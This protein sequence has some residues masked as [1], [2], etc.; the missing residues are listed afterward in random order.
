MVKKRGRPKG[1]LDLKRI[2]YVM[3][4]KLDDYLLQESER[5]SEIQDRNI[6]KSEMLR[7]MIKNYRDLND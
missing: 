2:M 3:D 6:S 1:R 7:L 5:Q 4:Q